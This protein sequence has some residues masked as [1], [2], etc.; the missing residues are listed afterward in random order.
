M[1]SAGNKA[2]RLS[3]VNHTTKIHHH[4][5]R[6]Q[7]QLLTHCSPVSSMTVEVI[8]ANFRLLFFF[9]EKRFYAFCAFYAH[10]KR[11]IRL[12]HVLY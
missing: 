5:H 3:S 8:R 10:K 6:Q 9:Y 12:F 11:L 1:V 7:Q 2:K 4:H